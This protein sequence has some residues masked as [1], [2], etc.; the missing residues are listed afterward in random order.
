[1]DGYEFV[2]ATLFAFI[3]APC[4]TSIPR[5]EIQRFLAERKY[6]ENS[7][8]AQAGFKAMSYPKLFGVTFLYSLIRCRLL[9]TLIKEVYHLKNNVI[10]TKIEQLSSGSELISAEEAFAGVKHNVRL[11]ALEQDYRLCVL[12]LKASYIYL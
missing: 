7:D 1:M 2:T 11:N 4:L 12:M 5:K 10:K 8:A 9:G 6:Y 3:Q